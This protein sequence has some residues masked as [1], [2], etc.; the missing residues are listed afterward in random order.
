[1]TSSRT[2]RATPTTTPP[3][4]QGLALSPVPDPKAPWRGVALHPDLR[5]I[6]RGAMAPRVG[7]MVYELAAG[8]RAGRDILQS[9]GVTVGE[10]RQLVKLPE[11]AEMVKA[12]KREFASLPNTADRV[13]LKAQVMTE[14]G[15]EEMWE[16][17][18]HPAVPAA[19]RVSAYN[20]VKSLTG[21]DKPDDP[22]PL[23][24]FSLKIVLPGPSSDTPGTITLEG[25]AH[26]PDQI[27]GG[28]DMGHPA[29]AGAVLDATVLPHPGLPVGLAGRAVPA[30]GPGAAPPA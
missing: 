1:M 15:L 29:V 16:I 12:A 21:L 5:G 28:P 20:S 22:Q 17:I 9:Y 30:A 6:L 27:P 10:F 2:S 11:F 3:L 26:A 13:R 7:A 4:N 25:S 18:R 23:Q 14:L 8:L 19:A 24:K